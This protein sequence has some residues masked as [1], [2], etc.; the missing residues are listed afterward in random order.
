MLPC[1]VSGKA[2]SATFTFPLLYW[3]PLRQLAAHGPG[4][5]ASQRLPMTLASQLLSLEMVFATCMGLLF[6]P[7]LD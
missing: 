7:I 6:D 5:I 3:R 4:A 1:S 2:R